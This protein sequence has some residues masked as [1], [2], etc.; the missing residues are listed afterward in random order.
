MGRY[1]LS[2]IAAED[3]DGVYDYTFDKWGAEQLL[4]YRDQIEAALEE[5]SEDPM[6]SGSRNR[7]DLLEGCRFYPVQHHYLAY[8]VRFDQVEVGRILHERMHFENHIS[9]ENFA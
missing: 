9:E 7:D 8:R 2:P 5:I 1:R 6:R 4:I 3:L